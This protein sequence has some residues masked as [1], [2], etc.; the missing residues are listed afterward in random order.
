MEK[1]ILFAVDYPIYHNIPH[2]PDITDENPNDNRKMMTSS[3][4]IGLFAVGKDQYG[5][6]ELKVFAIQLNY[7]PGEFRI[8]YFQ[9]NSLTIRDR[10]AI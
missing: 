1:G 5:K 2:V 10:A 8:I 4:P 3:S 6:N 9:T 7:K